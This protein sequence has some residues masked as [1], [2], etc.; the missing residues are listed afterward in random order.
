MNKDQPPELDRER[1]NQLPKEELVEMIMTAVK[2]INQLQATIEELKQESGWLF[3][4]RGARINHRFNQGRVIFS[5]SPTSSSVNFQ[6]KAPAFCF[7]CSA[8]FT[9]A[10][11]ITLP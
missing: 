5:N 8:V 9:P 6:P 4:K 10:M 7:T 3:L 2:A 1:L 11:G